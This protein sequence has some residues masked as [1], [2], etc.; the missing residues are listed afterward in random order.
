M[1]SGFNTSPLER[2]STSSGEDNP[3]V[4]LVKLALTLLSFLYDIYYLFTWLK[5]KPVAPGG[6][7]GRY[8]TED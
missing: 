4:T 6:A 1:V 5:V 2:S 3:M 7:T 8:F